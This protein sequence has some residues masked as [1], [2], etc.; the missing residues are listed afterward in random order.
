MPLNS[1]LL[2]DLIGFDQL[3]AIFSK[4]PSLSSYIRIKN[5]IICVCQFWIELNMKPQRDTV[6]EVVPVAKSI[7]NEEKLIGSAAI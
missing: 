3:F 7:P 6:V 4:T 2:A 5:N 1:E